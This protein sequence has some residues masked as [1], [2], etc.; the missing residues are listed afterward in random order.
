MFRAAELEAGCPGSE[1]A[2]E[3]NSLSNDLTEELPSNFGRFGSLS[4]NEACLLRVIYC[5]GDEDEEE[6]D[7]SEELPES[8]VDCSTRSRGLPLGNGSARLS[9]G[10]GGICPLRTS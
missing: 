1:A 7:D 8:C 6:D 9:S 5:D 10:M 4:T 2:A 3:D